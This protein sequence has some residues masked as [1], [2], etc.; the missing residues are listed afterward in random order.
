V[1]A[2]AVSTPAATFVDRLKLASPALRRPEVGSLAVQGMSTL[3]ACQSPSAE[4]QFTFG[5][6]LS[7]LS[8]SVF[9]ASVLPALSFAKKLRVVVP[10]A[11]TLMPLTEPP[12]TVV[13]AIVC[14]PLAEYVISFTPEPPALSVALNETE[15][16]VL[17]HPAA[18]AAGLAVATVVGAVA[19]AITLR[20]RLNPLPPPPCEVVNFTCPV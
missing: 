18:F 13:E 7:I 17:F 4:P 11:V 14:A 15:T 5:A 12:D 8:T 6:V 9:V 20:H 19:S 2:L 10:S 3:F 1:D 16:F